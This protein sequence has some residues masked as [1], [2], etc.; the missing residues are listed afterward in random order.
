M[1]MTLDKLNQALTSMYG[2]TDESTQHAADKFL[3][4]FQKTS[5]AW[6]IVFQVLNND[7][8][9][10]MTTIKMFCAQTLRSKINYDLFQLPKENWQGLKDSLLQ[11]IVKYDSKAKAIE[12]QLCVSL[13]NLALQYVEW[14]NA[15]DE[16]ISVLSSGSMASLL[17]FLKVLPEELSD[18]NK[19]PLTDEEFSLRTTQLITDNVE[20][21][22]L[23][24]KKFSDVK[25]SNGGRENSMVL[26]C[27]NSWIKEVSVDQL[28]KV[29]SLS[30]MIYQSI[31]N[32]ETFDT[33][34]ECLCTILRETTDV[35]DLTIVQTLYQQLLSLKDVIQ[36]SWDDP[37]KMEGLTRI[38]VEAGEAWHVLIPKLCEDFKPLVEILLQLTAYEDDLDT[39]KYTFFFWH[40]LRQIIII[41]KYAEARILFT[42][43]YTQLI[44][45]M[46]KHLS[47]PIVEPNTTDSSLLFST[48]Q[49]EDK[50]KDFRYEMGDVL[51]DCC[52]VIGASNAL[53]I[54]LNQI[55]SNVN[56][57]QPWQSIEAPIFSLRAMAEQVRSTENK[58][59][60]QVMQLLIK[61]PENP[62]IRYAVT[63]VLG[64]YTEWTSKHPE[65]LEGQLS[66][67]TD[68]FQ[69]NNNQITIAASHALMFFC[70]DCSSL[71]I[72]YLEQLFNFYNN[73]YSAG[74]LDIKSLYEVADGI[75]HI[76]QEEGDPE[77]LMQ[78]TAMFWK[79]T[80]E[81]LSSLYE[82]SD[83]A[84]DLQ[85]KIA[86]EIEVL[87][88]FVQVLRPSNLDSPSNP[89]AKLVIEQGWP[90]VT[91]LL[92]KFGKS[93]PITE[94]A[95]KFLNKS[96][97]SLSTY[98]EPI[99]PQMAELLV[100]GFQT[101][102]EGAYL[103]VSGIFIREYGDEHVSAQIKENVWKFSLQ[104]AASFI[105]FLEQ[106]Q[107]EI[108][109]YPDLLEDYFRMMADILMFFPVH[110]IQSELL[111]P[112]Y[113]S[114][115]MALSTFSQF[116]PL[117]ATLHFLIDLYSWGFETPP[118][119]LLET[120]VPP[121]IRRIILS[122]IESTGGPLTKVLLNGL[123]YR[124]P[125]DCNHDASDLWTKIIRLVS[126]NGQNGDLVLQW[127]NE[128]LS[129]LPE[130]TVNEKE[131]S[132]L[133]TTVQ[134]AMNSKDFRRVRASIRD[135]INWY[136]RKNFERS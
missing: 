134:A 80:I 88:I 114:A 93:T 33:A 103:W 12:T 89:I 75:A 97:S 130:G 39:V 128:A 76:L 78:L 6:T 104:Q 42:P 4:E 58:L 59:M 52:A 131:R 3:L 122:F 102:R 74:T 73:V 94:R 45:V 77:K 7:N 133:L 112:V 21:V 110:L 92:N 87:T 14:S 22:L 64:R 86:D 5:E 100:L 83:T 70:Q 126:I 125:V 116:E 43:I 121:E 127:L 63:L 28:L 69:S 113:N 24:L 27:L 38:F 66:Y 56:S 81:K 101:Y 91:K 18:V 123:V 57:N 1:T 51:K 107:S 25:D 108:T 20:R 71:L 54:P 129:S 60:P 119:S 36:E 115:I 124:F 10:P 111:Q 32:D 68:G 85:L 13:A 136:S 72:G 79:P 48:K 41:D 95:L 11:L 98:L 35:E 29:R 106:N 90:I 117:I 34:V 19:T 99:I 84:P 62:K 31:H 9:P 30:D 2:S 47:Y 135:F 50:F 82:I 49:Q 109:N 105:Q 26:D 8:D 46:I 61:L 23:I 53:S 44:H 40:Q 15:M 16:I 65:Y 120:D 118:V 96:M 17:E 132:K 55:Q 67:I 37:E